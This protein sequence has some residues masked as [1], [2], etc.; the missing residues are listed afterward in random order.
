MK[1]FWCSIVLV[2]VA[3][4][5]WAL[6]VQT[7]DPLQYPA[8]EVHDGVETILIFQDE[9]ALHL[10]E[11]AAD[12]YSVPDNVVRSSG[13]QDFYPDEGTYY[14][15]IDGERE[16]FTVLSYKAY[17]QAATFE[18]AVTPKCRETIL[19]FS[20]ALTYMTSAGATKALNRSVTVYYTDLG[21]GESDWQDSLAV[22]SGT[23]INNRLHIPAFY[24]TTDFVVVFD[25]IW[26][27][28][29]NLTPDTAYSSLTAPIAVKQHIVSTVTVRG[30]ASERSNEVDRPTD[31]KVLESRSAPLE[32]SFEAHPSPAVRFF[33]WRILRGNEEQTVRYDEIVRYTFSNPGGYTVIGSV[34]NDVCPCHTDDGDCDKDSTEIKVSIMES[35]LLV[36]N[37]FTPNGDGMNDEFRVLY[38]SLR[39]Y[40]IWVYN[41][42]GKLV[43]ESTDPSKGWDGMIYGR[44]PAAEGAYYYVIRALGTDAA[45]D[46]SYHSRQAYEKG[47]L[48]SDET[49]IGVYQLSGDINLLRGKQK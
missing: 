11:G 14:I 45:K 21:W 24:Q 6:H 38:R 20:P 47:K 26:H 49:Y 44:Q 29:L 17:L 12:V 10:T 1:R 3:V 36:P 32:V 18:V 23:M 7:L 34:S 37:V 40:H 43:Y 27:E 19:D 48:N 30:S 13:L 22:Y 4:S 25:S 35:Q 9:I 33:K 28:E 2:L 31:A 39:E 42:W 41:R 16:Y 8:V 46:A 15:I 5:C